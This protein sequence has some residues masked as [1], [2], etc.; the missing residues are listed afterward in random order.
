[1]KEA[2]NEIESNFYTVL[3]KFEMD[4]F[5]LSI[6]LGGKHWYYITMATISSSV[7]LR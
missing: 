5:Y 7:F 3:I 4:Q 1:M 2:A 6:S